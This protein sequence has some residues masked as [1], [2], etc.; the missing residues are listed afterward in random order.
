[1]PDVIHSLSIP[2]PPGQAF[3]VYVGQ[4]NVWWPRQGV[5][6]FSFAPATTRPLH[7]QFEPC[8]GGRCYETFAD[9]SE[10]AIGAITVWP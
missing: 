7:I 5:F 6:P 2:L 9:G 4:M 3:N 1:M 10:Y 8:L